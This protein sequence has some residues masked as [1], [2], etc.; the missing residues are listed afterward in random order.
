MSTI[1]YTLWIIYTVFSVLED[2][3]HW[4]EKKQI[5]QMLAS[6]QGRKDLAEKLAATV[7]VIEKNK[8]KLG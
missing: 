8:D 3:K 1:L 7:E 6:E 5:N 4:A 2:L